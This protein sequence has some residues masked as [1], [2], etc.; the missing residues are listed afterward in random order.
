MRVACGESASETDSCFRN[1]SHLLVFYLLQ[2]HVYASF[3][4]H[5]GGGPGRGSEEMLPVGER[6]H[7][8]GAG[9]SAMAS[10]VAENRKAFH[11]TVVI[12]LYRME[13]SESPAFQSALQARASLS[14]GDGVQILLWDNSPEQP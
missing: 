10:F 11:A 9:M 13:P 6:G 5:P 3:D 14:E 1:L 2:R 7:G 12:V 8:R 4:D